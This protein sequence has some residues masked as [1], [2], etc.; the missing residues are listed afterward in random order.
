MR[1]PL[2]TAGGVC[3]DGGEAG[4]AECRLHVAAIG[5]VKRHAQTGAPANCE[6]AR[7]ALRFHTSPLGL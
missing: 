6:G 7:C 3:A 2:L 1:H 5:S 4:R